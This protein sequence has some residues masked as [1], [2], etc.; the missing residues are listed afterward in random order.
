MMEGE[1]ETYAVY[2]IALG[3]PICSVG[4]T[5]SVPSERCNAVLAAVEVG[6]C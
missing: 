5:G 4:R 1:R 3:A 6:G 2:K